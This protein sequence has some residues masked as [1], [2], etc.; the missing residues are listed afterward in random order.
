MNAP[1]WRKAQDAATEP[2]LFAAYQQAINQIDDAEDMDAVFKAR[3]LGAE[4]MRAFLA[5][6][7]S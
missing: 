7:P 3:R 2:D 5:E 6:H 4:W 1:T